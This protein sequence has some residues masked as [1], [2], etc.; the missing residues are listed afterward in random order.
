MRVADSIMQH[1]YFKKNKDF[2]QI[3]HRYLTIN[4]L[5]IEIYYNIF[6]IYFNAVR[7][8]CFLCENCC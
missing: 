6:C 2:H 8:S 7:Q 5:S 4:N 1:F 3:K